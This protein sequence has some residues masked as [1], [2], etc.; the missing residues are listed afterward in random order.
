MSNTVATTT[1]PQLPLNNLAQTFTYA[2]D[3][4]A[5]ISV[6]YQGITYVQTFEND[7]TNITDISVWAAQ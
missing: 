5:T 3:F 4:I 2:G 1:I 6:V 7:G